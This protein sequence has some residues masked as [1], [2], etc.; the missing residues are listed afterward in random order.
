MP[1]LISPTHPYF[2]V[3]L[4][5]PSVWDGSGSR[6][7]DFYLDLNMLRE[8]DDVI[9]LYFVPVGMELGEHLLGQFLYVL[10]VSSP[11]HFCSLFG[12]CC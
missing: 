1:L 7:L 3:C 6:A 4:F 8:G 10:L 5:G 11:P 2:L 12:S 9:L